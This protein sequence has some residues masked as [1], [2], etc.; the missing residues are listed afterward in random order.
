VS[1][2]SSI[3]GVFICTTEETCCLCDQP[4]PIDSMAKQIGLNFACWNC[5]EKALSWMLDKRTEKRM[6]VQEPAEVVGA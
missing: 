6:K 4:I 1:V 3:I 5:V 2:S